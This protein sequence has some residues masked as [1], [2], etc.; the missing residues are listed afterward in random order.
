MKSMHR[1]QVR[2]DQGTA[3]VVGIDWFGVKTEEF[4]P[5][6]L[7]EAERRFLVSEQSSRGVLDSTIQLSLENKSVWEGKIESGVIR[8]PQ[9]LLSAII[10]FEMRRR[11]EEEEKKKDRNEKMIAEILSR[12]IDE[13]MADNP[14]YW[15]EDPR[16]SGLR[17]E[18][19]RRTKERED[20][21]KAEKEKLDA[22]ARIE[23]IAAKTRKD[24]IERKKRELIATAVRLT[25][26]DSQRERCSEGALPDD[27]GEPVLRD[28]IF[29]SMAKCP[30]FQGIKASELA[31]DC[32][33]GD[34]WS[35]PEFEAEAITEFPAEIW[36]HVKQARGVV[37]LL[38]GRVKQELEIESLPIFAT[39]RIWKHRGWCAK[40]RGSAGITRFSARVTVTIKLGG[41]PEKVDDL[42]KYWKL[43]R[44]F[45]I[46]ENPP[47]AG[48]EKKTAR[49]SHR[50]K[51]SGALLMGERRII[52]E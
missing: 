2:L 5:S 40:C 7:T 41:D 52:A 20:R 3:L 48:E 43:S 45:A 23:E 8:D 44:E 16:L 21:K 49:E 50:V 22:A 24:G 14:F 10:N 1:F 25:G 6:A 15:P 35:G 4:M 12:S 42:D 27:E 36:A 30:R 32:Q 39:M 31:C 28:F 46:G 47:R 17:A 33:D 34:S 11:L 13:N 38:A 29:A 51:T 9:A 19:K 37:G 26:N 18:I